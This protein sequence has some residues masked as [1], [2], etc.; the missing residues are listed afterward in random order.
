[1][2][3]KAQKNTA[4][5]NE[6]D[7]TLAAS[8]NFF[9]KHKKAIVYGGGGLLAAIIIVLLTHQFYI[10]PRNT[11]ANEALY[12]AEALFASGEY[13]KAL[14]GNETAQGFLAVADNFGCTKAANLAK[15]Y[16][17][18][19]YANLGQYNEAVAMLEDFSGCGDAMISPAAIGALGNCYA[20]LGQKEKAATTL[21]EAASAADNNTLSPTFLI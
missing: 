18:I 7:E 1:M 10:V 15:M 2:S 8:K 20:A 21:E 17:G 11:K 12:K 9:D 6:F 19:C 3:Q 13:E 4:P 5:V 14:N 16:A